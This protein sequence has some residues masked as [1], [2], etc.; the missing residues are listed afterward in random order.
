MD[1]HEQIEESLHPSQLSSDDLMSISSTIGSGSKVAFHSPNPLKCQSLPRQP[2]QSIA[3]DAEQ[4][5]Q[6][7]QACYRNVLALPQVFLS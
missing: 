6:P 4:L 3:S 2:F 1:N 7:L 5:D